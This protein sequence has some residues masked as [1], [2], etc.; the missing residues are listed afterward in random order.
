V[1]PEQGNLAR[2]VASPFLWINAIILLDCSLKY[3]CLHI[4][5]V[6]SMSTIKRERRLVKH[7]C[8][9]FPK[10]K[11]SEI[12]FTDLEKYRLDRLI[13]ISKEG[14]NLE[15]RHLKVFCNWALSRGYIDNNPFNNLKPLKTPGNDLS[16]FFEL[17]EIETVRSIFQNDSFCDL[18]EFYLLTGVRLR[19]ALILTGDHIDF[20]RHQI[21]ILSEYTKNKKHQI[22]NFK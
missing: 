9:F 13:I 20:R 19:E 11:L 8:A 14:I 2:P 18:I 3:R 21:R 15:F 17:E 1:R 22:I 5:R 16:R 12:G 10:E 4:V 7:F 6:Q